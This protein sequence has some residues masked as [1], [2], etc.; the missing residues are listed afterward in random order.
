MKEIHEASEKKKGTEI[1]PFTTAD[2][3]VKNSA[4]LEPI[5]EKADEIIEKRLSQEPGASEMLQIEG[6]QGA[7]R[8]LDLEYKYMNQYRKYEREANQLDTLIRTK[9]APENRKNEVSQ[10]HNKARDAK[11]EA[12]KY[13]R[14]A[15]AELNRK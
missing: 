8:Y 7:K 10:L 5:R 4:S 15:K 9:K 6:P 2:R 11:K 12:E 14:Y 1:S 3:E 13:N